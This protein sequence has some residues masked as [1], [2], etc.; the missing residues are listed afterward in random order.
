MKGT[1]SRRK[2]GE[3]AHEPFTVDSGTVGATVP[4][5]DTRSV[6]G[7]GCPEDA[8]AHRGSDGA[9]QDT[10]LG[11]VVEDQRS[12]GHR[13][14]RGPVLAPRLRGLSLSAPPPRLRIGWNAGTVYFLA[15]G[16]G[17]WLLAFGGLRRD[18]APQSPH[19]LRDGQLLAGAVEAGLGAPLDPGA[20]AV[21]AS[22]NEGARQD[23]R[24]LEGSE[25]QR[26]LVWMLL[27]L[28]GLLLSGMAWRLLRSTRP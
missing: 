8:M 9:L 7:S 23:R 1:R 5:P 26:R 21:S 18:M 20:L 13:R 10:G 2:E 14:T 19:L 25:W 27:V 24:G 17:P 22:R 3:R 12:R 4:A 16:K 28:G 11:D 6:R 15:Q